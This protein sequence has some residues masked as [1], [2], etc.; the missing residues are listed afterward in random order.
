[1]RGFSLLELSIVLVIIGLIA[2]GVVTGSS[3]IRAA[4]LRSVITQETQFKIAIHTFRDKYLGLPGDLKNATAF[5]GAEPAAHC[6]GDETTPSTTSATCNGDGDGRIDWGRNVAAG[7]GGESHRFW[8]HLANAELIS[9]SYT[10]V[11]SA[12][13]CNTD[14][15]CNVTIGENAPESSISG[16]GWSVA[17]NSVS[18]IGN[19][20][21]YYFPM[22]QQNILYLGR[23]ASWTISAAFT[24]AEAWN[25]DK[26]NDDGKPGTGRIRPW[27]PNFSG[28][29]N[30]TTS[31]DPAVSEYKLDNEDI[32]C[33]IISL[34]R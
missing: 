28:A 31:N 10:G 32:A 17:G 18:I 12:G 25:I 19:G 1:M 14:G 13:S 8:Q 26:K 29:A 33:Q 24:P 9:G 5:W 11:H 3:M 30:C 21:I 16:V 2:G 4:E 15:S 27:S 7:I 22:P 20:H 34:Q 23:Q 6:P